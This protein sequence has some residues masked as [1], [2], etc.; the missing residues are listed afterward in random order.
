MAI[1]RTDPSGATLFEALIIPHRSLSPLGVRIL[2][3]AFAACG[4][5]IA[6]RFWLLGAWPVIGFAVLEISL[7]A[8]LLFLNVRRA[9]TSELVLLGEDTLRVVRTDVAGRRVERTLSTAW[10]N[11]SVLEEAG[12]TPRLLLRSR[13]SQ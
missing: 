8:I 6:I 11:V 1:E 13:R 7:A 10:L 3:A 2:M 9:R 4:C 5:L 12:R